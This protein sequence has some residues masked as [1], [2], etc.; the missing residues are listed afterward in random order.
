M[1][2]CLLTEN[3]SINNFHVA[4]PAVLGQ[5]GEINQDLHKP[6]EALHEI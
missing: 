3:S 5:M 6:P 2:G 1:F 4:Q